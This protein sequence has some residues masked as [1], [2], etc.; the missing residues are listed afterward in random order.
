[1]SGQ[2][3]RRECAAYTVR[4]DTLNLRSLSAQQARLLRLDRVLP[5][6]LQAFDQRG[7]DW[8]PAAI[9]QDLALHGASVLLLRGRDKLAFPLKYVCDMERGMDLCTAR[10]AHTTLPEAFQLAFPFCEWSEAGAE[11]AERVWRR[12]PAPVRDAF[13]AAGRTPDGLWVEL[14]QQVRP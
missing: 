9:G 2:P 8:Q 14:A 10:A 13:C 11:L 1:M 12:V 5:M 4:P 6:T 7:G 3:T